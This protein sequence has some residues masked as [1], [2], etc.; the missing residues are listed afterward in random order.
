MARTDWTREQVTMGLMA[1][2]AWAE[3]YAAAHRDL[4]E[5]GLS[6]SYSTLR[7]WVT[8]I[9]REEYEEL[10]EKYAD[11]KEKQMAHQFRDVAARAVHLQNLALD[12]AEKRLI[13][14]DDH[15]PAK[16]AM[17]A[18]NVSHRAVDRLMALTNRPTKITESRDIGEV[19]RSLAGLGVL[20]PLP[21]GTTAPEAVDAEPVPDGDE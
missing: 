5:R 19:I 2:V 7:N 18:S 17:L 10:R 12:K 6:V 1:V 8:D 16:T 11:E 21:A 13:D 9:H 3:N 15:E 14:G 20:V 4:K